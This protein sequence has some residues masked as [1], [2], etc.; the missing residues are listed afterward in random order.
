[1]FKTNKQTNKT[2]NLSVHW[3][4]PNQL[5]HHGLGWRC[6]FHFLDCFSQTTTQI[7]PFISSQQREA[8]KLSGNKKKKKTVNICVLILFY[9]GYF[10][11]I[12]VELAALTAILY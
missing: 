9:H 11:K 6:V 10:N 2:G 5:S 3:T 4:M 7:L 8:K 12:S 1:M